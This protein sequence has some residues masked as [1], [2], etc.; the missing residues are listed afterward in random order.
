MQLA[1]LGLNHNTAPVEVRERFALSPDQV[2]KALGEINALADLDEAVL[3]STCNRTELY[4]VFDDDADGLP[5]LET[6]Y[7]TIAGEMPGKEHFYYY[8]GEQVVCHLFRVAAGM[9]SLVMGEGQ[10]LSQVKVSYLTAVREGTTGPV[11]NVLFQ[12]ALSIGK[13]VRTETHI[14]DNPVS[15]SYAAVKKANEV[16][17]NLTH[18][19]VLILGAGTMAE[20]MAKHLVGHGAENIIIANRHI[21]KAQ[22]LAEKFHGRA[23]PLEDRLRWASRVDVILT[24][25][26]ATEYLLTFSQATELMMKRQ[27]KPLVMIDIA[28]PR[29]ID[30]EAGE[31]DGVTLYNIDDLTQ[32]VE[33][34]KRMR[35]KEAET[36]Y[37]LI[38][39]A[40]Q[41]MT[42]RFEYLSMRPL[43]VEITDRFDI[44]RRRLVKKALIKMPDLTEDE[45]RVV[46]GMSKTIV[47]KLLREPMI[48]FREIAGSDEEQ[49][50]Q[51]I[52]REIYQIG[53]GK[54]TGHER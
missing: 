34:N 41:E 20:L 44:V 31:I 32:V 3:L 47:R 30:P 50:Y 27:G 10:I 37:P 36:A 43:M 53:D 12:R 28:V 49:V 8:K 6:V 14:A 35:A 39:E 2:R 9:N 38:E 40:V 25:T 22:E 46:E 13:K 24:S 45:R 16:L 52:L 54:E 1:V 23:V 51:N 15:V 29:D 26:G 5:A 42:E 4:A 11:L 21:E 48:K 33:E 19:R 17:G 18:C 7:R